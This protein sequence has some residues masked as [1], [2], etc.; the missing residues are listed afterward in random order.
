MKSVRMFFVHA[1]VLKQFAKC[2]FEII[3]PENG[4]ISLN[5]PLTYSR[6]GS[7]STRTTHPYYFELLNQL[8]KN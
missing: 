6:I 3:V 8:L 5:I 2:V 1:I 7:S 4:Y